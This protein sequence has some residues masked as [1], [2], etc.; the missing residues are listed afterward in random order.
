MRD[1]VLQLEF[2]VCAYAYSSFSNE[3]IIS[4]YVDIFLCEGYG[5]V[6]FIDRG[7]IIGLK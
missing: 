5:K 7:L 1:I 3:F 2:F 4:F 6:E